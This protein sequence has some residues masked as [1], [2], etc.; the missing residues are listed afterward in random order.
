MV[1]KWLEWLSLQKNESYFD[2]SLGTWDMDPVEFK[3]K[4]YTKPVLFHP[5]LMQKSYGNMLN[6]ETAR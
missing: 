5:Y 1:T 2:G 6:K 3:L 4:E